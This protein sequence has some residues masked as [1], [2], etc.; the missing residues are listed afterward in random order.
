MA[1]MIP[2]RGQPEPASF[3]AKVRVKGIAH[4]TSKGLALNK[5]LPSG[6]EVSPYWRESLTDLHVAYEGICAY[7]GIYF[8]RV[9]GVSVDHFIAKSVSAADIYEWDNYR[10][11]CSTMNSRKRDYNTVLD[12]FHLAKDLFHLQLSTGHIY[13]KPGIAARPMRLIEET[14]ETLGLDDAICREIRSRRYQEYLQ[15]QLP[16]DYLKLTSPFIWSEANRQGL[17]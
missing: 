10:L 3:N 7:L 16:A 8:E 1:Q 15:Y 13:P 12:P 5:P 6:T 9:G 4:L 11:A 17:L 14:I 2:V